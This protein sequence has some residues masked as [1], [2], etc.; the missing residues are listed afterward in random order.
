[1]NQLK[2]LTGHP[3][4]RLTDTLKDLGS[5]QE[6]LRGCDTEFVGALLDWGGT[7]SLEGCS[8]EVDVGLLV[9]GNLG[10]ALT[11]PSRAKAEER[12]ARIENAR[13]RTALTTWR[14]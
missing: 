11:N 9:V 7:G 1:M 2:F 10:E 3:A 6:G 5:G 14:C 13:S 4:S 8:Q 12:S